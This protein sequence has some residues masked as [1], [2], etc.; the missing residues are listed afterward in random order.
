MRSEGGVDNLTSLPSQA[1]PYFALLRF[2]MTMFAAEDVRGVGIP[3][4]RLFWRSLYDRA[5]TKMLTM[6]LSY[7]RPLVEANP[8]GFGVPWPIATSINLPQVL[9]CCL[10]VLYRPASS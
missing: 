1:L 5:S 9:I 7:R 8:I 10:I 6:L 2:A 3:F 4:Q